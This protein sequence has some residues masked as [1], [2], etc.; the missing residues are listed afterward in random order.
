MAE[1]LVVVWD[2]EAPGPM[3]ETFDA[4]NVPEVKASVAEALGTDL[5][6][7]MAIDIYRT[8][9]HKHYDI[10]VQTVTSLV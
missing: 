3:I 9:S 5:K 2:S 1:Y 4:K 10:K 7:G 6:N 8:T